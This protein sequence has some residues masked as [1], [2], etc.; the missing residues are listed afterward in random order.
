MKERRRPFRP[1]IGEIY[2][3]HGGGVFRCEGKVRPYETAGK[4][5]RSWR[6]DFRNVASGWTFEGRGIHIYEDGRIDW[7]YSVQGRFV[8]REAIRHE[9]V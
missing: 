7:D 3:N 4:E 2:E 6:A 9:E 1:R 8:C 5:I